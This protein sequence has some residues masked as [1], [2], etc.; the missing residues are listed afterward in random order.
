MKK[1]VSIYMYIVGFLMLVAIFL[2]QLLLRLFFKPQ[3]TF[4]I[5]SFLFRLTFKLLFIK[6]EITY[7]KTLDKGKPYIFM[8]NHT[9]FWDVFVAGATFPFYVSALEAHTHFRWPI[10]GLVIKAYGQIPI[11]RSNPKASWKSF[12]KAIERLHK[13]K[14]SIIVF[15]EGTRSKDGRLQRFKKIP[16]KFAK[17]AGVDLV[18]V[19]FINVN[20]LSPMTNFWIQPVKIKVNFG[21]PIPG[22][23]IAQM[24][25]EE[26][27]DRV[28]EEIKR[29]SGQ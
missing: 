25:V 13:E 22:E 26:L 23:Q 18:P 5:I 15:P 29:L 11:N 14:I 1:L 24:S 10:Y 21:H 19:G 2:I 4:P 6:L 3:K 28:Y 17:E 16:F 8:A 9:S 20:N 27:S 7:E 12:L